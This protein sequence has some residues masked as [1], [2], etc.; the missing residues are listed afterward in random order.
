MVLLW[1]LGMHIADM[2]G[3]Q[4]ELQIITHTVGI[5]GR[6]TANTMH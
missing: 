4:T 1:S 3:L 6:S 2:L 5:N